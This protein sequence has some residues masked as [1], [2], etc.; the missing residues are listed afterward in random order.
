MVSTGARP[1][2][3][4]ETDTSPTLGIA[5][6]AW[7]QATPSG[8]MCQR[9]GGD[10][11]VVA[12]NR[13][14]S[15]VDVLQQLMSAAAGTDLSGDGAPE[16]VSLDYTGS[17]V[18]LGEPDPKR[19]LVLVLVEARLLQTPR[20]GPPVKGRPTLLSRLDR[21]VA[22]IRQ[23]GD[24]CRL[25]SADLDQGPVQKDGRVLLA[26]RRYLQQARDRVGLTSVVMIGRFPEAQILR[27]FPW[28]P[29]FERMINGV[30]TKR[31][32]LP[33][34][35][36]GTR[37]GQ[38]RHRAG[39]PDRPLGGRLPTERDHSRLVHA[40]HRGQRRQCRLAAAQR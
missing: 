33:R 20:F 29:A 18:K 14:R 36:P 23:E 34:G 19:R 31:S 6:R 17:S 10:S 2:R 38:R 26:L 11:A 28:A 5:H 12:P 35:R 15:A 4:A 1:D 21:L 27:G 9:G 16:I 8:Q 32:P 7:T 40:A 30:A 13:G 39:R 3:Y 22:D 25:V 37:G 24:D